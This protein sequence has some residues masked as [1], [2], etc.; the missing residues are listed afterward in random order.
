VFGTSGSPLKRLEADFFRPH[1]QV[2]ACAFICLLLEALFAL[3]I[4]LVQ[5]WFLDRLCSGSNE[6]TLTALGI[7]MGACFCCLSARFCLGR[8]AG[9]IMNRVSLEVVRELTDALHRKVQRLPL[10]FLDRHQTGGLITR[11]TSDV[12]TLLILLNSGT[13]QLVGDLVLAVGIAIVLVGLN[14][15]LGLGALV[16]V[17]LAAIG[18]AAF[19]R[20]ISLRSEETRERFMAL[21][22][23]LAERLRALMLIRAFTQ[24]R[25]ELNRFDDVLVK[26]AT[27]CSRSLRIS[28]IHVAIASI[29]AGMGTAGVVIG[30][31]C[32]VKNGLMSPGMLLTFLTLSALLYSPV[33]RLAQ[34][35]GGIA[36]TRVAVLRMME[37]LDE[38]IPAVPQP[39]ETLAE[40]RGE[41]AMDA[42]NFRF[43]PNAPLVLRDISFR[44]RP[45]QT[46]GILGPNGAGKST[47]LALMANLYRASSGTV[48]LDGLDVGEHAAQDFRRSVVLVAQRPLL[49]EGT[50][51][52]NLTYAFPN[53]PE[54]RLW[55]VLDAVDLSATVLS[56]PEGLNAPL[57]PGGSGLSG[58][59][60]Q[61][62]ALARAVLGEPKVLLLDDCTSALDPETE[63]LVWANLSLLLPLVTRVIVS[64]TPAPLQSADEILILEGGRMTEHF[65]SVANCRMLNQYAQSAA[66]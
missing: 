47:L 37:L 18:Q 4:P 3:P 58:G 44:I 60:K 66:R 14:W 56:R 12:G 28:A 38:P 49:F 16:V 42:V 26:H 10:G 40:I 22:S 57:G 19:R 25:S 15:P 6:E 52:S 21:V 39:R 65:Q 8:G 34:F 45:S 46:L 36:A 30:G 48:T 32:L 61:R 50:I 29:I 63:A 41:L 11:L 13:I 64:Q 7:T 43:L 54:S 24:E 62:L 2:V 9:L 5:G 31:A 20:P 1:R 33:S 51:R 27:A 59:Q 55:Q 17:P 53:A 35:Q 23:H